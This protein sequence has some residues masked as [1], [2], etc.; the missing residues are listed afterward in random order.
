M[1]SFSRRLISLWL[2]LILPALS[3]AR[4]LRPAGSFHCEAEGREEEGS[5][6]PMRQVRLM[7]TTYR[8]RPEDSRPEESLSRAFIAYPIKRMER[9]RS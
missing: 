4:A 8:P 3:D 6:R 5:G 2:S 1:G 7:V 9:A